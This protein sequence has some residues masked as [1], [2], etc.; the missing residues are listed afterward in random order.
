MCVFFLYTAS[1]RCLY[2]LASDLWF[3]AVRIR[4]SANWFVLLDSMLCSQQPTTITTSS[5]IAT[6]ASSGRLVGSFNIFIRTI[7]WGVFN[8]FSEYSDKAYPSSP[9][10]ISQ[11]HISTEYVLFQSA[12][13]ARLLLLI[14]ALL[15]PWC[16]LKRKGWQ[17]NSAT[18]S[19]RYSYLSWTKECWRWRKVKRI[20]CFLLA[21]NK[22]SSK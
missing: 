6:E 17:W 22:L 3:L 8:G 18:K 16:P 14:S 1:T 21:S 2:P 4:R 9:L 10:F 19:T 11:F 20:S 15:R 12:S 13:S 7:F 5:I